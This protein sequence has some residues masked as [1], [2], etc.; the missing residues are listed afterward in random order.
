MAT[1]RTISDRA[2]Q[3]RKQVDVRKQPAAKVRRSDRTRMQ[4]KMKLVLAAQAVM[5]RVGVERATIAEIAEEADVG[6][7]SF[8]NHF[9]SKEEIALA[10]F[11]AQTEDL[12]KVLEMAHE[13]VTDAALVVSYVQRLII[14]KAHLDPI[15]GWFIVRAESA[16]PQMQN[17]FKERAAATLRAGIRERRFSIP[18]VDVAIAITL[19]GLVGVIRNMLTSD[20]SDAVGAKFAE[21]MLRLY[22]ISAKEASSIASHPLPHRLQS[23]LEVLTH[24]PSQAS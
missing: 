4:T 15:W 17:T 14:R 3:K 6:F 23:A 18:D 21:L 16:L 5:A 11:Q 22:G 13:G 12:A 19:G 8:Y 7:G 2:P 1:K 24:K 10:V 9:T 20:L